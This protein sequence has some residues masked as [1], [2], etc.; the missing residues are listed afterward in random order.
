MV[1]DDPSG[2]KYYLFLTKLTT[3][4]ITKVQSNLPIKTSERADFRVARVV[5][6]GPCGTK[7]YIYFLQRLHNTRCGES[8]VKLH[9]VTFF[10][11]L[12]LFEYTSLI[13]NSHFKSQGSQI[14]EI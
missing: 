14:S 1:T 10:Y 12:S 2:T 9:G 4:D 6:D 7:Y 3:L 8:E 13:D 5:T 11:Q